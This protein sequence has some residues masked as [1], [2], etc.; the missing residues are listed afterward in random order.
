MKETVR[1]GRQSTY[2]PAVCSPNRTENTKNE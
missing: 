2:S 1:I